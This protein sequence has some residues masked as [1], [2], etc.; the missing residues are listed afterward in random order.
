MLLPNAQCCTLLYIL[1]II[2]RVV[3]NCGA[4]WIESNNITKNNWL[5]TTSN[6]LQLLWSGLVNILLPETLCIPTYF[7]SQDILLPD[8]LYSSAHFTPQHTL[9][10]STLWSSAHFDPQHTLI[11]GAIFSLEHFALWNTLLPGTIYFQEHFVFF[12]N[13]V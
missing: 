12:C 7:A 9:H 13:L 5:I 11:T 4:F 10:L 8:T 2:Q 6:S 1:L 3:K